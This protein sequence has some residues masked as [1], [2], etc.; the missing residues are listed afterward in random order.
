MQLAESL[1]NVYKEMDFTTLSD[2]PGTTEQIDIPE[3]LQVDPSED[4]SPFT[5]TAAF[6][7]HPNPTFKDRVIVTK[8]TVTSMC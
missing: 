4:L 7:Q 2:K 8:I 6:S 1:L 5:A 3:M